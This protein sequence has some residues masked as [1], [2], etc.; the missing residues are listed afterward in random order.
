MNDDAFLAAFESGTLDPAGFRHR[1]H[2][3][4]AWICLDR[5]SLPRALERVTSGLRRFTARHG[6]SA[7]FHATVTSAWVL[8]V[9]DRRARLEEDHDWPTFEAA[10]PELFARR[11]RI[12]ERYYRPETLA[13]ELARRTFVMPDA[14][15][16]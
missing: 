6:A 15:A 7:K 10:W 2:V 5:E 12:L 16:A 13:S 8:L 11:P 4:L 14:L 9:H 1:D 3:R